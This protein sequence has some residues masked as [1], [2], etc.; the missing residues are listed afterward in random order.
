MVRVRCRPDFPRFGPLP[1]EVVPRPLKREE[2]PIPKAAPTCNRTGPP[3]VEIMDA[4][5]FVFNVELMEVAVQA[6]WCKTKQD[7]LRIRLIGWDRDGNGTVTT[8]VLVQKRARPSQY[9]TNFFANRFCK[10]QY[11]FTEACVS[12]NSTMDGKADIL[13]G[14]SGFR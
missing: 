4:Y 6:Y 8:V 11:F 13:C 14:T 7:K 1:T 12:K 5:E 9:P 3:V 2:I 10:D